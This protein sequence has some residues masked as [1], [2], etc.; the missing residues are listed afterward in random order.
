MWLTVSL[1]LSYSYCVLYFW[2]IPVE[3]ATRN[4]KSAGDLIQLNILVIAAHV[5]IL[6]FTTKKPEP[7]ITY[8]SEREYIFLMF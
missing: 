7:Y 8:Q 1:V 6:L 5:L 4:A 2:Y 3:H